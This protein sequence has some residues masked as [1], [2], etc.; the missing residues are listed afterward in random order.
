MS[1]CDYFGRPMV[2][3]QPPVK[4]RICGRVVAAL[5]SVDGKCLDCAQ[6][7]RGTRGGYVKVQRPLTGTR[8]GSLL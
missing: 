4:C 1:R 8:T 6:V 7:K 3:R 2:K 5:R